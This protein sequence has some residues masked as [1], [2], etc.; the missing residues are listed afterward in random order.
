MIKNR[1][2]WFVKGIYFTCLWSPQGSVSTLIY[3]VL[4]VTIIDYFDSK[5]VNLKMLFHNYKDILLKVQ[6]SFNLGWIKLL[7][8]CSPSNSLYCFLPRINFLSCFH[9]IPIFPWENPLPNEP[10]TRQSVQNRSYFHAKNLKAHLVFPVFL[11]CLFAPHNMLCA[12]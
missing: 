5:S 2:V 6:F 12:N 4:S 1:Q 10:G 8:W 7:L 11:Q 3:K 9:L